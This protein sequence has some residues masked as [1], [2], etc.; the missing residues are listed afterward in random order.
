[1]ALESHGAALTPP[2]VGAIL[3]AMKTS[4]AI[5]AFVGVALGAAVDHAQIAV[6]AAPQYRMPAPV[7]K[8]TPA[9]PATDVCVLHYVGRLDPS[10]TPP[11][12]RPIAGVGL[13]VGEQPWTT[14]SLGYVKFDV[15][16]WN[17]YQ[18]TVTVPAGYR[19]DASTMFGV[20]DVP[21]TS[22]TVLVQRE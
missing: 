7:V 6:H 9:H 4:L 19:P 10:T 20:R 12:F 1:V 11:T 22:V 5:L 14:N 17:P 8:C 21:V 16:K 18:I 3:G 15:P 13:K 2:G